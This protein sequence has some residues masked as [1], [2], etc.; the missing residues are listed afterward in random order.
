[1]QNLQF[2]QITPEQLTDAIIQGVK[3]ELEAIKKDFQP[4]QPAEY[5]TRQQVADW[6]HVDLV[7]VWTWCKK[8]KLKPYGLGN[9]VLFNRA[10]VEA[11]LV[12]LNKKGDNND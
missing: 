9:R 5:I 10:E 2:I 7:T 4:K 11:A 1:M 8:G 3:T 12:P 6:F